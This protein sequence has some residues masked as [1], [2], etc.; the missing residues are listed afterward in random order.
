MSTG[1]PYTLLKVTM[2]SLLLLTPPVSDAIEQR[3]PT[4]MAEN[5][6]LMQI[7]SEGWRKGTIDAAF[8][9][10]KNLSSTSIRVEVTK[11][12]AILSGSVNSEINKS[13]AKEIA[14]SVEGIEKVE[15]RLKVVASYSDTI[16]PA[17]NITNNKAD[18]LLTAKINQKL[19]TH[20]HLNSALIEVHTFDGRVELSGNA[21]SDS[22]KDLAYYLAKNVS[23]VKSVDNKIKVRT[24]L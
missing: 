6:E 3:S 20:Q 18:I 24:R 1:L 10:N 2:V 14:L 8:L 12:V 13:L 19:I 17:T 11:Q 23:G 16:V 22:A 4:Q 9:L 7:I 21:S 5:G 15:N